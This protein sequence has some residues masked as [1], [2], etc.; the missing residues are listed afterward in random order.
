MCSVGDCWPDCLVSSWEDSERQSQSTQ[1]SHTMADFDAI[2]EDQDENSS[3]LEAP[4]INMVPD[5]V[6]IRGA[7][8]ITV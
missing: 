7:G 1:H 4:D 8:N 3:I 5:P 2:Y 6:I